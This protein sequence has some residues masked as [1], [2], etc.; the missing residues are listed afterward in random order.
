MGPVRPKIIQR[1]IKF[2]LHPTTKQSGNFRPR[3][4]G[5]E[6]VAIRRPALSGLAFAR[7]RRLR[8]KIDPR[9]LA[10]EGAPQLDENLEGNLPPR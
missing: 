10:K 1:K 7:R 8:T 5:L 2:G 3:H 4:D 9:Q 6:T